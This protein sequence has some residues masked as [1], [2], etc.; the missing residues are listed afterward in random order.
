MI[1]LGGVYLLLILILAG[2]RSGLF[3]SI[4]VS[5]IFGQK[6]TRECI[7]KY[8]SPHRSVIPWTHL[9]SIFNFY[10]FWFIFIKLC[11]RF[12]FWIQVLYI[13]CETRD[14][15][16]ILSWTWPHIHMLNLEQ[17]SLNF[18]YKSISQSFFRIDCG[19]HRCIFTIY[20]GS[21]NL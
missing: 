4:F 1:F 21:Y 2:S 19:T 5:L 3:F 10:N 9:V 6:C 7:L 8:F 11:Y 18:W 17:V 12:F 15:L 14:G 13:F 20:V 16:P